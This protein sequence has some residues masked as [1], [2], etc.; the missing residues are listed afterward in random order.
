MMYYKGVI[1]TTIHIHTKRWEQHPFNVDAT[2]TIDDDVTGTGYLHAC[3]VAMLI[4]GYSNEV[5]RHA[6]EVIQEELEESIESSYNVMIDHKG[7]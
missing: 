5:I 2:I 4:E 1:M 3:R 6:C 7:D